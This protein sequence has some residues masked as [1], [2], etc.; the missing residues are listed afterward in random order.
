M[1]IT[2]HLLGAIR[3][4]FVDESGF[5]MQPY[6]PYGWQKK[7]QQVR[8]FTRNN[9]KRLN[10]LGFISADLRLSVYQNEKS[11]NSG[12]FIEAV[13]DYI[14]RI[15]KPTVL[16]LDNS[17]IHRSKA[18][19]YKLQ[20][21]QNQNL[22]VFFLPKYAP[23]LNPIEILWKRIKYKWLNKKHYCSFRSLKKQIK[24]IIT[25][26]GV[27]YTINFKEL[28]FNYLKSNFA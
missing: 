23:H 2:L 7:G 9:H 6:L 19:Y 21:W 16:V 10:L 24:K 14:Q 28:D 4:V 11:I 15:D 8:I 26:F 3:L 1:L 20:Q 13:E 17:P 5:T 25:H 12:F 22:Y 27:E 18:V